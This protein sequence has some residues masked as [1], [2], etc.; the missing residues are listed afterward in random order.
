MTT[1]ITIGRCQPTR[2]S[3]SRASKPNWGLLVNPR[4]F[5]R[6]GRGGGGNR[7]W[8][9]E[10]DATEVQMPFSGA[11][12]CREK[13][14]AF[15]TASPN[16]SSGSQGGRVCKVNTLPACG[17][18]AIR[19]VMECPRSWFWYRRLLRPRPEA[20]SRRRLPAGL[21]AQ[22]SA[23]CGWSVLDSMVFHGK[24][25][26]SN[27]E[28]GEERTLGGWQRAGMSTCQ[29][30][31]IIDSTLSSSRYPLSALRLVHRVYRSVATA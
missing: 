31:L 26:E 5:S 28:I 16:D 25:M 7:L 9:D 13:P 3:V 21:G 12:A 15:S 30:C 8:S 11:P 27:R 17:P 29:R 23:R 18:T 20:C 1:S 4:T 6:R 19:S 24:S 10:R 14:A 22:E 2:G